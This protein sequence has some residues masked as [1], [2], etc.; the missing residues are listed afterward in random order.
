MKTVLLLAALGFIACEPE[1]PKNQRIADAVKFCR[2]NGMGI[3]V[4]REYGRIHSVDCNPD[5]KP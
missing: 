4:V 3:E 5:K 2:N 1:R